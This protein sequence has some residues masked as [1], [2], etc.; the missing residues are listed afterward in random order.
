[1]T[2]A[3]TPSARTT[4]QSFS[5][6]PG[7]VPRSPATRSTRRRSSTLEAQGETAISDLTAHAAR[8][9]NDAAGRHLRRASGI[10]GLLE[11]ARQRFHANATESFLQRSQ[12]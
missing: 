12:P 5:T 7:E 10:V 9:P 3:I 1:S 4:C 11:T 2:C 6:R 8:H